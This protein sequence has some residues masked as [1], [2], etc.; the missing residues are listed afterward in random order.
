MKLWNVILR[1]W[2]I[3]KG[4]EE[5][6]SKVCVITDIDTVKRT[7]TC[8]PI[9]DSAELTDVR[10]QSSE[11]L[12]FGLCF[13]PKKGSY[14]VVSYMNPKT[15]FISL[16]SEITTAYLKADYI[17]FNKGTNEGLIN[18]KALTEKLNKMVKEVDIELAK[19]Q[20]AITGLGGTY[21]RL[22]ITTFNKS[23]FE[24]AKITH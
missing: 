22:N 10:L 2:E 23:D 24:D 16:F 15:A 18:I 4:R 1:I 13:I 7:C 11:S 3:L 6:Y 17:Q 14:V 12:D 21:A 5:L 20:G 19:I 9:D 8:L